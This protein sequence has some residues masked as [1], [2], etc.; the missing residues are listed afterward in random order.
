MNDVTKGTPFYNDLDHPTAVAVSG[1]Y[2]F[3]TSFYGQALTV[4][5]LFDNPSKPTTLDPQVV[6]VLN[7]STDF[8]APAD[9]TVEGNY[10]Y[11]A[12][13]NSSSSGQGTFTVV[14][15]ANPVAPQVVGT[16]NALGLSGGYRVRVLGNMAYV[17]SHNKDA[18]TNIDVTV[19]ADPIVITS[20]VSSV[21]L[22]AASGLDLMNI[23]GNQYIVASS[24]FLSSESNY[25]YPPYPSPG[26]TAQTNNGT[27]SALVLEAPPV[28]TA[29]PTVS[30]SAL[31]GRTLTAQLGT[32]TGTAPLSYAYQWQRCDTQGANCTVLKTPTQTYP[33]GSSDLGHTLRVAVKA[34]NSAGSLTATS[35]PTAVVAVCPSK[36][37]LPAYCLRPKVRVR[38][39]VTGT[40]KVGQQ[41]VT[42]A[43]AWSKL[44]SSAYT[45]AQ[46]P[47]FKAQWL[48][49]NAHGARCTAIARATHKTYRPT[50]KDRGRRL[51]VQ[52]IATNR[53][54]S[55]IATSRS[56]AP[57]ASSTTKIVLS[58]KFSPQP[59]LVGKRF[60]VASVRSNVG[61]LLDLFLATKVAHGG[62]SWTTGTPIEARPGVPVKFRVALTQGERRRLRR[63]L[64]AHKTVLAEVIGARFITPGVSGF[65]ETSPK[66]FSVT[67]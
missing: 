57:I 17:A 41:L 29:A 60:V 32:W 28:N 55:T 27:I 3:V 58:L 35:A 19:P 22:S 13:Q 11:V 36:G 34:S 45:T 15:I 67:G 53:N 66:R 61:A 52:V 44:P 14:D 26:N 16:V 33:I 42:S 4:I 23:S 63:A 47:T 37:R 62:A 12:N 9:I 20:A 48:R 65:Q 2:A 54:G 8:S 30:G 31:A 24:P 25:T 43:G 64:T 39:T 7:D 38:P 6:A 40:T 5:N 21:D 1:N 59:H 50:N 51:K 10:A 56:S 46:V 18:V 49:C